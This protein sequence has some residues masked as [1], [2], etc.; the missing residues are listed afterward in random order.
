[1]ERFRAEPLRSARWPLGLPTLQG[2]DKARVEAANKLYFLT[3]CV[4]YIAFQRRF[5]LSVENRSNA[6][7]WLAVQ[8]LAQQ[9]PRLAD[10]WFSRQH[11]G[12]KGDERR[13]ELAGGMVGR[14]CPHLWRNTK[15][16]RTRSLQTVYNTK[17]FQPYLVGE[18]WGKKSS[19]GTVAQRLI[20]VAD[21]YKMGDPLLVFIV[22]H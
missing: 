1:M 18:K 10:A 2:K 11:T 16:S 5:V 19:L 14:T 8:T 20:E 3:L 17:R 12:R 9:F 22:A 15:L 13:A 7:F 6:Y 4:A 21:S